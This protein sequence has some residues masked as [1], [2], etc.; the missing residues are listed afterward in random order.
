MRPAAAPVPIQAPVLAPVWQ[1]RLRVS[2]K[3]SSRDPN[4]LVVRP[5]PEG[6]GPPPGAREAILVLVD[7]EGERPSRAHAPESP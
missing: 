1:S 4:L 6:Q 3:A 2:V 5:L 7:G